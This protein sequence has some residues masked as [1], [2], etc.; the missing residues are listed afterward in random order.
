LSG[1]EK[2]GSYWGTWLL[3][4]NKEPK[5]IELRLIE[6]IK[7]NEPRGHVAYTGKKRNAD[8]ILVGKPEGKRLLFKL[9]ADGRITLK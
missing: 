4:I 8:K 1:G 2:R 6:Q 3:K 7:E 9:D 5:L